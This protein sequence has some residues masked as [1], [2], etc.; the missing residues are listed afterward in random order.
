M[1][2]VDGPVTGAVLAQCSAHGEARAAVFDGGRLEWHRPQ[3]R[4]APGQTVVLYDPSN[5][6]VL[7][8]GTAT[9]GTATGAETTDGTATGGTAVGARATGAQATG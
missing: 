8:G 9:G 1:S 7:G 2:W 3:R 6:F 5:R 4:V